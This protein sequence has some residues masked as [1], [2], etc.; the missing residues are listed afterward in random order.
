MN[1]SVTEFDIFRKGSAENVT[2][3]IRDQRTQ[4]LVD[5][6]APSTFSLIKISDD[7]VVLTDTFTAS[8]G[9]LVTRQSV[10]IYQ[11]NLDTDIYTNEYLSSF[12]CILNGDVLNQ[13]VFVKSVSAKHFKYAA[14]LRNQVDKSRKSM[15]DFLENMDKTYESPIQ[16]FAGYG[17][18]NLIFY[19]ERGLQ[20]IN[21]V[22]PY[23]S[24][25]IDSFPFD[26]FGSLLI[27]AAT[28]AALESQGVFAIDTDYDYN[29]GGNSFVIDHFTKLSTLVSNILDRFKDNV[30]K[31]KNLYQ[32]KGS[33]LFQ[34]TPAGLSGYARM[35]NA[36]PSGYWS[37][38]LSSAGGSSLS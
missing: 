23:T 27:D 37:R 24:L 26:Q 10:G 21:I 28:I 22:P 38:V 18:Q 4:D 33:L 7:D 20:Y 15:V 35:Y 19:I 12:R 36:L 25:S 3:F 13:N 6:I 34:P 2:V 30:S 17:D 16:F 5:V 11:F 14:H 31:F 8:G 32:N 9:A 1:Y 29:L